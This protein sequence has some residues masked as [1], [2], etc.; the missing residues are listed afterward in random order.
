MLFLCVCSKWLLGKGDKV[1]FRSLRKGSTAQW[2]WVILCSLSVFS[3]SNDP[4]GVALE[5][6]KL[7]S[8]FLNGP[9]PHQ[10]EVCGDKSDL[11][12]GVEVAKKYIA[13]DQRHHCK[14]TE[15]PVC[16]LHFSALHL[17]AGNKVLSFVFWSTR[18]MCIMKGVILRPPKS[19]IF[20]CCLYQGIMLYYWQSN[21]Q[22][23]VRQD[24][25][26]WFSQDWCEEL[27]VLINQRWRERVPA[28]SISVTFPKL[29]WL[30]HIVIL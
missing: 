9:F 20:C 22:L 1:F 11:W 30:C 2:P 25:S 13:V 29:E 5:C 12:S 21:F 18:E 3:L 8:V 17:S 28:Y 16:Y 19:P 4:P 15:L 24:Q 6:L 7:L 23:Q 14:N 27:V 10:K 26:Q